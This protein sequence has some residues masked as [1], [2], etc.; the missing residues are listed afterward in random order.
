MDL[1]PASTVA[2]SVPALIAEK[3]VRTRIPPACS[4]GAGTS[5]AATSPGFH[6]FQQSAHSTPLHERMEFRGGIRVGL[7]AQERLNQYR[8]LARSFIPGA[9]FDHHLALR[10]KR[11][12]SSLAAQLRPAQ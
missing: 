9:V 2:F 8:Q 10:G 1:R 4:S 5:Y 7:A 3:A 6:I 12:Q 11:R